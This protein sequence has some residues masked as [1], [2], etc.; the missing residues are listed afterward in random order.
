MKQIKRDNLLNGW[1]KYHDTNVEEVIKTHP[2]EVLDTP[3]W[4]KLYPVTQLQHDEWVTWAKELIRKTTKW[5]KAFI[6]RQWA[7][8]YFDCAPNIKKHEDGTN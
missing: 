3:D 6:D 5:N 8:V 4:F 1:L 7:F 2:K